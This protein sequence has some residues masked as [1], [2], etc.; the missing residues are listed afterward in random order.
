MKAKRITIR[1]IA[2]VGITMLIATAVVGYLEN[3]AFSSVPKFLISPISLLILFTCTKRQDTLSLD[4][5][6]GISIPMQLLIITY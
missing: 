1:S 3:G 6:A 2:L 5:L 4:P